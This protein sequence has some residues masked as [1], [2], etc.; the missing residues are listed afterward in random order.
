MKNWF[1]NFKKP[2][3]ISEELEVIQIEC[4]RDNFLSSFNFVDDLEIEFLV[5]FNPDGQS[6]NMQVIKTRENYIIEAKVSFDVKQDI[7]CD[8]EFELSS[9]EMLIDCN[10]F[11]F[12]KIKD[13]FK[14]KQSTEMISLNFHR[15]SLVIK[16]EVNKKYDYEIKGTE[17][18]QFGKYRLNNFEDCDHF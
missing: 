13:L 16:G 8:D 5:K 14:N 12:Q 6:G 11:K 15:N 18:D 17:F 10:F 7:T 9:E 4:H 1:H 2:E 3:E